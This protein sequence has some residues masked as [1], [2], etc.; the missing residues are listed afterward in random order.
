[1]ATVEGYYIGESSYDRRTVAEEPERFLKDRIREPVNFVVL[2][3]NTSS[4]DVGIYRQWNSWGYYSIHFVV[5]AA[6]GKQTIIEKGIRTWTKNY[7]DSFR[8][9][10]GMTHAV[11][12][13]FTSKEW[14][15]VEALSAKGAQLKAV[16][17]QEPLDE[18]LR[19]GT[20]WSDIQIFTNKIESAFVAWE[21]LNRRKA[22]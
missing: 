5:T 22:E 16:F 12:I 15:G 3:E 6:D 4:R 13:C 19:L 7:P 21:T 10:P 11:P 8:L 14:K 20:S 2:I 17:Q 9:P 1:L 18:K